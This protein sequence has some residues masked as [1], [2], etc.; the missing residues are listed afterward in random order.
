MSVASEEAGPP[1]GEWANMIDV[2][3]RPAAENKISASLHRKK[4]KEKEVAMAV[5][6]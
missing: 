1:G 5:E 6:D 2:V 3:F 4:K